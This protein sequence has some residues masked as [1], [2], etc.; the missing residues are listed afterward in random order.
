MRIG[1]FQK[2]KVWERACQIPEASCSENNSLQ[3]LT[4]PLHLKNLKKRT[5]ILMSRFVL[6]DWKIPFSMPQSANKSQLWASHHSVRHHC[7]LP[8]LLILTEAT[9]FNL[10]HPEAMTESAAD[11]QLVPV[12]TQNY[13]FVKNVNI[14]TFVTILR[15]ELAYSFGNFEIEMSHWNHKFN[16][17]VWNFTLYFTLQ[18]LSLLIHSIADCH[19]L[20]NHF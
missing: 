18:Y 19:I 10:I 6:S 4:I 7:L 15:V 20:N 11:I 13:C 2:F 12:R 1:L 3:L 16:S 17:E 5:E 9:A 8:L 14:L